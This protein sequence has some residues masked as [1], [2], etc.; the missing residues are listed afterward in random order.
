MAKQQ[1]KF[2][3]MT[4]SAFASVANPDTGGIYFISDKNEI[5]KGAT[6]FG[7]NKVWAV[8]SDTD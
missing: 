6:R 2:Y 3:S 4:E 8:P 1:V 5:Y 7:A